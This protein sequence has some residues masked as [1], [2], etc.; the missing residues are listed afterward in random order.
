MP[1][2]LVAT[3]SSAGRAEPLFS[4]AGDLVGRGHRVT[5]MTGVAHAESVRQLGARLHPLPATADGEPSSHTAGAGPD[6]FSRRLPCQTV[7]FRRA[8][9][10]RRYDVVIMDYGLSGIVP[11]LS[12]AA[13]AVPPV[14]CYTPTPA[15]PAQLL[16]VGALFDRLIVPTV[17]S[18]E[19]P[20]NDLPASLRFVGVVR[21]RP[22]DG[23][24]PP[25]WWAELDGARPVVHVTQGTDNGDL[26]QLVEP[27]IS[28]LADS[29]V[30]VVVS[31]GGR[32]PGALG[33]PLPANAFV[34][35]HLPQDLLLP[36]VDVLVTDGGYATVQP[37]LAAGVPIVVAGSTGDRA[38]VA[39]RVAWSG[40]GINLQ[41][42]TPSPAAI[43][44]AVQ[45]IRSEAGFLRNARRLE[46]DFARRDGVAEIAALVDE[47]VG[48]RAQRWAN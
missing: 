33:I 11:L 43:A 25:A 32:D 14:L 36:K 30:T 18:F 41:T 8:L 44:A 2:I 3:L 7:E 17:P 29:D 22:P 39:A 28:A 6:D 24:V 37:A 23:F 26:S 31:T 27:C 19:Y 48:E 34:A 12:G 16:E 40:T 46:A 42:G 9:G 45:R 38:E 20:H 21:P 4:V 35:E 47:V 5:V 13:T 1:E 15:V 10:E